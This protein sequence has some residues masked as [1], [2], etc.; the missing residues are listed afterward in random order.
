MAV[1][2]K[3]RNTFLVKMNPFIYDETIVDVIY[4]QLVQ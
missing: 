2:Q 4:M 1:Y 3:L